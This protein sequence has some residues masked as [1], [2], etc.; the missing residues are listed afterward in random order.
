MIARRTR[1]KVFWEKLRIKSSGNRNKFLGVQEFAGAG[2]FVKTGIEKSSPSITAKTNIKR[3]ETSGGLAAIRETRPA[4]R[5][6]R[7]RMA[8][9]RMESESRARSAAGS[10]SLPAGRAERIA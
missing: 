2:V 4:A 5:S 3:L 8:V 6:T 7:T 9:R 1:A 10:G